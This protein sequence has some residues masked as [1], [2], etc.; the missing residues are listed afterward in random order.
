MATNVNGA[1]D[2]ANDNGFVAAGNLG[3]GS[4]GA[5]GA[6]SRLVWAP[7]KAA[8]RAGYVNQNQWD[9]QYVGNYSAA[10]G[11]GN[12]A[13][14]EGTT[15]GGVNNYVTG[16]ASSAFGAGN[17][18]SGNFGLAAGYSNQ[19]Y[20]D[21]AAAL[22]FNGFAAGFSSV[23]LGHYPSD[24]GHSGSF[25]F[26]DASSTTQF[27][28]SGVNEFAAR[29]SGGFRL[30]SDANLTTGVYLPP[31]DSTWYAVSDV[32]MKENFR[33][34]SGEDVLS[35]LSRMPIREWNY[36]TQSAAVRH[37]GLTAQDFYG[38]FGLGADPLKISTVDADGVALAGIQALEARTRDTSEMVV[39][40]TDALEAEVADLRAELARLRTA[41]ERATSHLPR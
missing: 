23:V 9:D 25:V 30:Y 37:A 28:A 2:L 12:Q 7:H 10:F 21:Y 19:I 11:F 27:F 20:G 3:S 22:G 6:G 5:I 36:K 31:G 15:V 17:V 18:V 14:G 32:N 34:L 16:Y 35:K 38:A 39:T 40:R 13:I 1:Y 8:F 4:L 29:A 26:A 24:N 33:D 41:L